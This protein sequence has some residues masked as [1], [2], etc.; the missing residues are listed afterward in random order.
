LKRWHPRLAISSYHLNGD[1][2]AIAGIAWEAF[3][4]YRVA[5]KDL[6]KAPGRS[7][8]PKVLFFY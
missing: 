7:P 5:S 4:G 2:A 1:P 8:V 6:F 3:P